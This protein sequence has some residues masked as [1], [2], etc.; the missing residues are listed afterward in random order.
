M[1]M[2]LYLCSS[3]YVLLFLLV[4]AFFCHGLQIDFFFVFVYR[5]SLSDP[6]LYKFSIS[7]ILYA[8][9]AKKKFCFFLS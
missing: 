1:A 2:S 6:Y 8:Q 3:A 7:S 5:F 9:P 4:P